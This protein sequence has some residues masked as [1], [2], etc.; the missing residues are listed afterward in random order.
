[1]PVPKTGRQIN[2]ERLH[3]AIRTATTADLQ[4]A[5]MFLEGAR[6]VRSGSKIQRSN[7]RNAQATAWKKDVD[8]SLTW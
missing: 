5:A 7:S 6:Q 1:M 3:Q 2:L 8:D 4:R